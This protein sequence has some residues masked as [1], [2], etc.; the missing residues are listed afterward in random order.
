MILYFI[1]APTLKKSRCWT[2]ILDC[3]LVWGW[4]VTAFSFLATDC[5]DFADLLAGLG[6]L[7]LAR[8]DVNIR[9]SQNLR[10]QAISTNGRQKLCKPAP[11]AWSHTKGSS[12]G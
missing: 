10:A 8:L 2:S 1:T 6:A 5:A 11:T 7:G 9:Q 4:N 12:A 3:I